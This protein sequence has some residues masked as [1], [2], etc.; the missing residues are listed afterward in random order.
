M[1]HTK[2]MYLCMLHNLKFLVTGEHYGDPWILFQNGTVSLSRIFSTDLQTINLSMTVSQKQRQKGW[3]QSAAQKW[4]SGS[5]TITK[6]KGWQYNVNK[7]FVRVLK[8]SS[9]LFWIHKNATEGTTI[10]SRNGSTVNLSLTGERK[11]LYMSNTTLLYKRSTKNRKSR[12]RNK[13][14]W[15]ILWG[16]WGQK[17]TYTGMFNTF[18]QTS[19]ETYSIVNE[20]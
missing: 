15:V 20:W 12:H 4:N 10:Y 13:L 19:A 6:I 11:L 14:V 5:A 17:P 7:H 1:G 18:R 9:H 3:K 2:C 8:A 16:S